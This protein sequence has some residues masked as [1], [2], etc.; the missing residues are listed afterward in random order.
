MTASRDSVGNKRHTDQLEYAADLQ[1]EENR[2]GIEL[3]RL[4]LRNSPHPDFDGKHC[5]GCA[6][7]INPERLRLLPNCDRCVDCQELK[8]KRR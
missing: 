6:D 4:A 5:V 3:A 2:R 8:E 7:E 1:E